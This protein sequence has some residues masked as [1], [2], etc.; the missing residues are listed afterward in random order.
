LR[1]KGINRGLALG[2]QFS[3]S[4]PAASRRQLL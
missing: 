2:V 4:E 3:K 1:C